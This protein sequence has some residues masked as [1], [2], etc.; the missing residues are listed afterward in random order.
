MKIAIALRTC[1]NVYSYW[2]VKRFI[3]SSKETIIL[4]C[5]NSLLKS[6]KNS[7]HDIILS[8]HDDHSD[9]YLL[10]DINNLCNK[11]SIPYKL[12]NT[13]RMEN[14]ESQYKW[15]KQQDCDYI[16][17]V[18]D[19]YLHRENSIDDM[20]DVCE[21]MK[22]FWKG[23]EY[24]VSPMNCQNRYNIPE[25]HYLSFVLRGKKDYW[26]S[27]LHSTSTFFMSKAASI[28]HDDILYKQAYNWKINGSPEHEIINK[29]WQGD[30]VRLLYPIRSLAWHLSEDSCKDRIDNWEEVWNINL[31]ERS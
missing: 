7:N 20:L 30:N 18:E 14:F 21:D 1:G 28:K 8:I 16:Y 27:A 3:D 11:Y 9:N 5:L 13:D 2:N 23:G 6:I 22:Q 4:T 17:M 12:F 10:E 25:A 29:L 31:I 24:A 19:D 15:L 26:R